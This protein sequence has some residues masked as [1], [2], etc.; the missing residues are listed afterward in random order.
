[1]DV[2]LAV[3]RAVLAGGCFWL[4][5]QVGEPE[6]PAG[7]APEIAPDEVG[8]VEGTTRRELHEASAG[9][10][11]EWRVTLELQAASLQRQLDEVVGEGSPWPEDAAEETLESS[12]RDGLL[13]EYVE[14]AGL[15]PRLL[16]CTSYP[17]IAVFAEA[18]PRSEK[19]RFFDA[20]VGR[21]NLYREWGKD[22]VLWQSEWGLH[23]GPDGEIWAILG[24]A[25]LPPEP[26]EELR[27]RTQ[28]RLRWQMIEQRRMQALVPGGG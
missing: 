4:G 2:R 13:P 10:R 3:I 15:T 1:M 27:Q 24:W 14:Q 11:S 9:A 28:M 12:F 17:C 23:E 8:M 20:V 22:R 16:D 6:A 5:L 25:L 21:N 18:V 7:P 19:E 26:S